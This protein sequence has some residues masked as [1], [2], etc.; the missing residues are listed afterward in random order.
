M[1][2]HLLLLD[3][4]KVKRGLQRLI[5]VSK[6]RPG[7]GVRI[8]RP[9]GAASR[10]VR[11][12]EDPHS[13]PPAAQQQQPT[14]AAGTAAAIGAVKGSSV[15]KKAVAV[16]GALKSGLR[17]AETPVESD[18]TRKA[19]AA[20]QASSQA[21]HSGATGT[22]LAASDGAPAGTATSSSSVATSGKPQ[23]PEQQ[24][25]AALSSSQPSKPTACV[26]L[27]QISSSSGGL[28]AAT[29][30]SSSG[31]R[32]SLEGSTAPAMMAAYLQQQSA[33]QPPQTPSFAAGSVSGNWAGSLSGNWEAL[34]RTE[35]AGE[36]GRH[37]KVS[38]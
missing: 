18:P 34:S 3:A 13:K 23:S 27:Q 5:S 24:P 22:S 25:V 7:K 2:L 35:L 30:P 14:W 15:S 19:P 10:K 32:G 21:A 26:Q 12:N 36:G 8:L 38:G 9:G 28:G 6:S 29:Y 4:G 37:E 31:S 17:S 11:F 1:Y 33:Q 16:P 20:Q